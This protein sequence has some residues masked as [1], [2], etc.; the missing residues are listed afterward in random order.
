M[1]FRD[2][3]AVV[4]VQWW[5]GGSCVHSVC[6]CVCHMSGTW[7]SCWRHGWSKLKLGFV[8]VSRTEVTEENRSLCS[9]RWLQV[10]GEKLG[11]NRKTTGSDFN[12][13]KNSYDLLLLLLLLLC[14]LNTCKHTLK[15]AFGNSRFK[16][17]YGPVETVKEE[18]CSSPIPSTFGDWWP[19]LGQTVESNRSSRENSSSSCCR[20]LLL[21]SVFCPSAAVRWLFSAVT[22]LTNAALKETQKTV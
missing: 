2:T 8:N 5:T 21:S 13:C 12:I 16:T 22:L 17:Q 15:K 19:V 4:L 11:H 1:F 18:K 10:R 14:D 7:V 3:D 9:N 20:K 6:V